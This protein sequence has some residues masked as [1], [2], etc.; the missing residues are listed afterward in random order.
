MKAVAVS[1]DL[2]D[3][4]LSHGSKVKIEGLEGTYVVLDKTNAR[5]TKRVDV[6]MGVDVEAAKEFGVQ[7]LR[8]TWSE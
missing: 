5:F 4:G 2:L 1:P 6:Y 3:E 7:Q 8:V